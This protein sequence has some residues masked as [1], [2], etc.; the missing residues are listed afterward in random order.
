MAQD[1]LWHAQKTQN[2]IQ[3]NVQCAII[4]LSIIKTPMTWNLGLLTLTLDPNT[5]SPALTLRTI[6]DGHPIQCL[7]LI[8]DSIC[9]YHRD[10]QIWIR[11][12]WCFISWLPGPPLYFPMTKKS[13]TQKDCFGEMS[14]T[15]STARL[16]CGRRHIYTR[17][18]I[19]HVRV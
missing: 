2:Q 6:N 3:Y 18:T 17:K 8:C 14:H 4:V 13:Y 12:L 10:S 15:S 9:D 16:L 5:S 1:S 19:I 7:D 11:L